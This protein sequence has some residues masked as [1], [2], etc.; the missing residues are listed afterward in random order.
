MHI[1]LHICYALS[2]NDTLTPTCASVH[3]HTLF[4]ALLVLHYDTGKS[5]IAYKT[6]TYLR[7]RGYQA[8]LFNVGKYRRE[9]ATGKQ[10]QSFFDSSNA[11]AK[12][13]RE[14][15]A[16]AV[17]HQLL[18]W[19]AAGGDV[20]V[21]D[22]TNT[23][24]ERRARVLRVCK[25]RSPLLNVVFVESV[26][27]DAKVL[28]ENYKQKASHSPDYKVSEAVSRGAP[29]L[30]SMIVLGT[31]HSAANTRFACAICIVPRPCPCLKLYLT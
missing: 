11:A 16:V 12:A 15:L 5:Y 25:K 13:Q 18:D 6:V 9:H 23:T 20:A 7:W 1:V 4:C 2:S 31:K 28:E 3:T 21:F 29:T 26:C 27:D 10:D 8:D 22:A 30:H 17:L 14:E 19:L 24:A